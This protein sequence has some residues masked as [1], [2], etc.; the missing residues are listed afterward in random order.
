MKKQSRKL[1]PVVYPNSAGI[2]IAKDCHAVA[3]PANQAGEQPVRIFGGLTRDLEEIASW[4]A[5]NSIEQVALEATGVYWISVYEMLDARGFEVWLVNPTGLQRPD[6]RKSDVLDC[7]WIQQL[8]SLGMLKRSHRPADAIC[9][10]RSYVRNRRRAI[11]DR[12]RCVQH[13][14]KAL[15]QMN[16]KLDSV[17]SDIAGQTG[18]SI[19]EAIVAGE[20]DGKELAKFRH[21]R[22]K[23]S[24]E[25]IAAALEGNWRGEHLFALEQALESY[26]HYDA[27]IR[28]LE[29]R[30][31]QVA[32]RLVADLNDDEN[33]EN[34]RDE[35]GDRSQDSQPVGSKQWKG[36]MRDLMKELYGV[37]LMEIPSIGFE[38]VLT[39]L[40]E[41]GTDLSCFPSAGHFGQWL[42]LAPGT[43]ISG[44][45]RLGGAKGRGCQVSGQALRMSAMTLRRGSS[46]LADVHRRRCARMDPPRAIKATAYQLARIIYAMVT[47]QKRYDERPQIESE[48]LRE[49]HKI[50]R[51]I[52][53][54]E[55]FG[56]RLV[57]EDIYNVPLKQAV[58]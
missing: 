6:R 17:L 43:N 11:S 31:A 53:Q 52:R 39:L 48:N 56:L 21:G 37:D 33:D 55:E 54:A 47:G 12:A 45:K 14:Q 40:S 49:L 1:L 30:I 10:L 32:D 8:M 46:K 58:A 26:R 28:R 4:L 16:L 24:G 50:Q 9:E 23:A 22:V 13:M 2:D 15:Q 36:Q 29:E 34:G 51:I 27:Q 18:M 42:G 3:L 57:E 38:T 5:A 44:G 7:Q 20:R 35:R 19:I 41:V 25:M